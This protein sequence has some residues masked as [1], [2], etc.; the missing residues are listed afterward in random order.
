M[1][2]VAAGGSMHYLA[3]AVEVLKQT[4]ATSKQ[5]ASKKATL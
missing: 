4:V 5:H 3:M 2:A 1:A